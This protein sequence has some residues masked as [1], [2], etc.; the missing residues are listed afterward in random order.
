MATCAFSW[1]T[2][3]SFLTVSER[4]SCSCSSS[5]VTCWGRKFILK[6]C[7]VFCLD[8]QVFLEGPCGVPGHSEIRFTSRHLLLQPTLILGEAGSVHFV[9]ITLNSS[10]SLVSHLLLKGITLPNEAEDLLVCVGLLLLCRP[11][12]LPRLSCISA[13]ASRDPTSARDSSS[14]S[15]CQCVSDW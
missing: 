11:L 14:P 1:P 12:L 15:T 6:V 9:K 13:S 7:D 2:S 4:A 5:P 3:A 8:G 10:H